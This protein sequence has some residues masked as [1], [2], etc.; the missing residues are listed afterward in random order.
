MCLHDFGMGYSDL[1]SDRLLA[2]NVTRPLAKWIAEATALPSLG[3]PEGSYTL[4]LDGAPVLE[5]TAKLFRIVQRDATWQAALDTCYSRGVFPTPS[6]LDRRRH[7]GFVCEGLPS[8]ICALSHSKSDSL[9][10]CNFDPGTTCDIE[11]M[12]EDHRGWSWEMWEREW[13]AHEP[14]RF[15]TKDPL[16]PWHMLCWRHVLP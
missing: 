15:H 11:E 6:W 12:L 4:L 10:S 1:E 7:G 5:Q 13:S 3:M 9:I 2:E 14:R 16:P 8:M